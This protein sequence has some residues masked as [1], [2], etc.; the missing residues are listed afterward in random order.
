M[1]W[2]DNLSNQKRNFGAK[3]TYDVK[4][5]RNRYKRERCTKQQSGLVWTKMLNSEK[6]TVKQA[7]FNFLF[8]PLF[9]YFIQ[10]LKLIMKF[11]C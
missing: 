9:Y 7:V 2:Y 5:Y 3:V 1:I 10:K 11:F 4:I 8:C 6:L